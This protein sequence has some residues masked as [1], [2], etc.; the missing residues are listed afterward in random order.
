MVA[1]KI[2]VVIPAELLAEFPV[3]FLAEPLAR[4][5]VEFQLEP[6][7]DLD[8]PP[9]FLLAKKSPDYLLELVRALVQLEWVAV[10]PVQDLYFDY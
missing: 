4:E 10:R 8:Y 1:I 6:A 3:V 9:R 7:L 5:V 2:E